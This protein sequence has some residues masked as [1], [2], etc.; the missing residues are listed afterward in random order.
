MPW[1]DLLP[2]SSADVHL[3][4]VVLDAEPDIA[5]DLW[6]V[7]SPDERL[8]AARFRFSLDRDRYILARGA[9]RKFLSLYLGCHPSCVVLTY[10]PQGK[11]QLASPPHSADLAFNLSHSGALAAYAFASRRRVGV[12][13]EQVRPMPEWEAL[14]RRFFSDEEQQ[15]L[16]ASRKAQREDIFFACWT[17]KEAYIKAHGCGL[18]AELDEDP[19][20]RNRW[21]LRQFTPA[22]NYV[23]ALAVEGDG[24]TLSTRHVACSMLGA[25]VR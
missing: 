11:P 20:E 2:L 12:D 22:K 1:R 18:A 23:G 4:I 5:L 9:L 13:I 16:A 21:L 25:G 14:S 7:L 19:Q 6:D 10:G 8:R 24:W 17:R 3:W 15:T